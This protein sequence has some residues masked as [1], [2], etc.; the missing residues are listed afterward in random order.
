MENVVDLAAVERPVD[1]QLL[2]FE[3]T[4]SAQVLDVRRAPGEEIVHGDD[5]VAFRQQRVAQV[6]AEEPGATG[7]Q[8]A[9]SH[10]KDFFLAVEGTVAGTMGS[11]LADGR[12]TL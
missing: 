12:P 11:G 5:R 9:R 3:I 7:D 2:K 1:I 6:R 10:G 8:R 4:F